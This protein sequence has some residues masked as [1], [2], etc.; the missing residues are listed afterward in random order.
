MIKGILQD[1]VKQDKENYLWFP[2]KPSLF[3]Q[4]T[5]NYLEITSYNR[6]L[7]WYHWDSILIPT[8]ILIPGPILIF[9]QV[10][11]SVEYRSH[12]PFTFFAQPAS[13]QISPITALKICCLI[14]IVWGRDSGPGKASYRGSSYSWPGVD[15]RP[16]IWKGIPWRIEAVIKVKRWY[17]C[18]CSL[19]STYSIKIFHL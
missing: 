5:G 6:S 10:K 15:T 19:C 7:S 4:F 12:L 9:Q 11:Y 16:L 17:T 18:I 1:Q 8:S 2:V 13:V 14:T 3:L